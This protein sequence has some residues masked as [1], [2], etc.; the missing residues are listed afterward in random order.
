VR[1]KTASVG[2]LA[3]LDRAFSRIVATLFISWVTQANF[4][5]C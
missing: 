1:Q 3:K 2:D 5:G 4:I